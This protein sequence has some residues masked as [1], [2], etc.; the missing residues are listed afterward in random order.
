MV[1]ITTTI[2]GDTVLFYYSWNRNNYLVASM[3]ANDF[4]YVLHPD[5]L[6][7]LGLRSLANQLMIISKPI[8]NYLIDID[9]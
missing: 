9:I 4:E 6:P 3:V 5:N 7:A 1:T 8:T 2:V